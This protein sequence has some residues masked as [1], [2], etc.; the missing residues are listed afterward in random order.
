MKI[1]TIDEYYDRIPETGRLKNGTG[2]LE[3]IRTNSIIRRYLPEPPCRILDMGGG[4]GMYSFYLAE[5]GHEVWFVDPSAEQVSIVKDENGES[6]NKLHSI[7]QG[8][9]LKQDLPHGYFDII[10]AMGPF[11]HL[12]DNRQR[13]A[14]LINLRTFLA[15]EGFLV[16][17]Y[18]S[19]FA[20]LQ[21]GY[22]SGFISNP[23]FQK[24]VEG[25]LKTGCHDPE[26]DKYFTTAYFHHP[27]EIIPE[28]SS[29][30]YKVKDLLAVEG[31]FWLLDDLEELLMGENERAKILSFL[32]TIEK[33]RSIMGTSAH[34]LAVSQIDKEQV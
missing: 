18:I 14:G 22:A 17:A 3:F 25:D 5:L 31:F 19:R 34:I 23:S 33:D 9:V 30:G 8:D 28:L 2:K 24:L 7:M 13:A 12:Q 6:K 4:V 10:L 1:N 16:T 29:A 15:P 27:D 11:Y 26:S 20:S 21:D 32:D